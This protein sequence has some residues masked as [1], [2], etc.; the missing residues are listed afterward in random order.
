MKKQLICSLSVLMAGI[1]LA[2]C[3]GKGN[4]RPGDNGVTETTSAVA[5]VSETATDKAYSVLV[6]DE[7]GNPVPDVTV[8]FCDDST[9]NLGVTGA[10]GLAV[11]ETENPGVFTVHM[12]EVPEGYEEDE[13][14][15]VTEDTYS[16]LKVVLKGG[17]GAASTDKLVFKQGGIEITLP[18]YLKNLKGTLEYHDELAI[19]D[20][21]VCTQLS[22]IGRSA[23]EVEE[24]ENR[25]YEARTTDDQKVVE[26]FMAYMSEYFST[27]DVV[28]YYVIG[29]ENGESKE[30]ILE[31]SPDET[32]PF[33]DYAKDCIDLGKKGAY[34]YYL[35]STDYDAYLRIAQ[36]M[37]EFE[38]ISPSK[39]IE[40]EFA[41]ITSADINDFAKCITLTD[42]VELKALA[43]GDVVSFEATDFNGN[44]VNSKDLFAGHKLT[45]IN[46]WATWCHWCVEE[47]PDLEKYNE[48]LEEKDCQI[49]GVCGD[50][51]KK[52]EIAVKTL[53]E[54]GVTY[55][56][57]Y[58]EGF[59]EAF[60]K[61][62]GFPTTYIVDSEGRI[63]CE[64]VIGADF[65]QYKKSIEDSLSAFE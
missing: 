28:L 37:G 6:V 36:E 58:F 38:D 21:V 14:E 24:F 13:T 5:Q 10:D 62:S 61:L 12:L 33:K 17:S 35:I 44:A 20:G 25:L 41:R 48:E 40:E 4:G 22:Y 32:V 50:G 57:V 54:A 65:E 29:T 34:Q 55:T 45:M 3:S 52:N 60:P 42:I 18:E 64:P 43:P 49:V 51:V 23:K 47:L 8:Q 56:N 2:G 16:R 30:E 27:I 15:Y 11:F 26:D 31:L 39:E 1:L 63:V 9:C 59:K 7:S 19:K 53:K 46:I